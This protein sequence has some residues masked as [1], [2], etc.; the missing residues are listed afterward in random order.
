RDAAVN[1]ALRNDVVA[2][3]EQRQ[4]RGGNRVHSRRK[5]ECR[6]RTLKLGNCRL[7]HGMGRVAI[8]RIEHIGMR[9]A[10]L[11]LGVGHLKGGSLVDRRRKR[12]ILLAEVSSSANRLGFPAMLMR[13]HSVSRNLRLW[14][15][16]QGWARRRAIL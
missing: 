1:I 12:P 10:K 11:L 4:H 8:A 3:L 6:I 5:Q 13:F 16:L 9:C 15:S 14:T 7:S 2:G